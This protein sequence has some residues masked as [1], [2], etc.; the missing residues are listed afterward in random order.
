[1][2]SAVLVDSRQEVQVG[3]WTP[4]GGRALAPSMRPRQCVCMLPRFYKICRSEILE[5]QLVK[6]VPSFHSNFPSFIL[7]LLLGDVEATWYFWDLAKGKQ[8]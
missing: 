8:S 6:T 4:G 7:P 1:M 3:Q 5:L 2:T